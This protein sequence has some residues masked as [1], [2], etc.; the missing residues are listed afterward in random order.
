M[1]IV[2][3]YLSKPKKK[4]FFA[5]LNKLLGLKKT[6]KRIN[7]YDINV[8]TEIVLPVFHPSQAFQDV[9]NLIFQT[10]RLSNYDSASKMRS[11]AFQFN[12]T[13]SR[14]RNLMFHREV[15]YYRRQSSLSL[16]KFKN[17]L[18]LQCRRRC[19]LSKG[20][21]ICHVHNSVIFSQEILAS[22]LVLENRISRPKQ[23]NF[24]TENTIQ[25]ST[26]LKP[27]VYFKSS[28]ANS[29]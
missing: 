3:E 15:S 9:L 7:T 24:E 5:E 19:C 26:Q 17:I 25:I 20:M 10:S 14:R 27:C 28:I 21:S 12:W 18:T 1:Q 23:T 29:L 22:T 16:F 6:M 11:S 4:T 8:L 13:L 2:I